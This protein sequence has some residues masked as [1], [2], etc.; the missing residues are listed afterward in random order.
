MS[1]AIRAAVASL[2]LAWCHT[3][4]A[5]HFTNVDHCFSFDA[6]QR[7]VSHLRAQKAVIDLIKRRIE[8]YHMDGS[9]DQKGLWRIQADHAVYTQKNR[10][11][12][13]DGH[14]KLTH[15]DPHQGTT[16][17]QGASFVFNNKTKILTSNQ[18]V[19]V[20]HHQQHIRAHGIEANLKTKKVKL[21]SNVMMA[22]P[23]T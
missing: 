3:G 21:L 8:A 14:C 18:R 17:Y 22:L 20:I 23:Q 6:K 1:S 4:L 13:L 2:V 15:Q 7:C 16:I 5:I 9:F 11:L 12:K 19:D 10:I